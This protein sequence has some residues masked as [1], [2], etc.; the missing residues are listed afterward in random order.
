MRKI[1]GNNYRMQ[2]VL[3]YIH[4]TYCSKITI[5]ILEDIIIYGMEW[6]IFLM[7]K[8]GEKALFTKELEIALEKREVDFVVHSLKVPRLLIHKLLAS[9]VLDP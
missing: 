1:C 8:I 6:Q 5:R 4:N 9:S 7:R 2:I 3:L